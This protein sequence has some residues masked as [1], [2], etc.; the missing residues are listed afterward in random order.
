MLKFGQST[1]GQGGQGTSAFSASS[2]SKLSAAA[3]SFMPS[4]FGS[5]SASSAPSTAAPAGSFGGFGGF[6]GSNATKQESPAQSGL[7]SFGGFGKEPATD[8]KPT[9][10]TLAP[11]TKSPIPSLGSAGKQTTPRPFPAS[12][13]VSQTPKLPQLLRLLTRSRPRLSHLDPRRPKMPSPAKQ[14][15]RPSSLHRP[16]LKTARRKSP[17]MPRLDLPSWPMLTLAPLRQLLRLRSVAG[18]TLLRPQHL[19]PRLRL[20]PRQKPRCES[21]AKKPHVRKQSNG[22]SRRFRA[23]RSSPPPPRPLLLRFRKSARVAEPP[24]ETSS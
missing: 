4:A 8:S 7:P 23:K 1:A 14:R 18:L 20:S 13:S 2:P 17:E 15:C 9:A 3:T 16:N 6:G 24:R 19:A 11:D 5:G 12:R 22:H 10:T 21:S